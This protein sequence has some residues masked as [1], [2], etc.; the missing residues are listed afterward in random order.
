MG[1]RGCLRKSAC[2]PPNSGGFDNEIHDDAAIAVLQR[3][4]SLAT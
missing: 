1:T 2:K 4:P 3:Q